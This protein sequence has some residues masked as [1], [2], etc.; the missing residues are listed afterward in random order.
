MK[1]LLP[2]A[3]VTAL[4]LSH[5]ALGQTATT[6]PVGAMTYSL[7]ATSSL[8]NT[9]ISVPLTDSPIF[10]GAVASFGSTTVT[11]SGTPFVAGALSQSGSPYFLRFQSGAQAGRTMLITA[12][13][14]DTVTVDVTN[15]SAQ[16]TNLD[17][18]GFS[19]AANDTV[20]IF[21][22]DTLAS[23]FGSA[24]DTNGYLTG[25]ALKGAASVL[26]ADTVSI[27]NRIMARQDAYFFSTTLGYWRSSASTTNQNNLILYPDTSFAITRRSGRPAL[28]F[29]VLGDVPVVPPKIKT[30]GGNLPVYGSNPF[31]VDMTLGTLNLANW[32]K[33]NSVLSAD[34]IAVYNS[35]LAKMDAYYQKLDGTW[36]K[37]GDT[38]TDQSSF[39]LPAGSFVGFV[40]RGSVSGSS[41]FLSATLPYSF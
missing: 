27:Y 19:V 35:T 33:S 40:K 29:T 37:S 26:S 9:Y 21:L 8:T 30:A 38:S 12:N 11:F 5:P 4:T 22:G 31:P 39:V 23:F 13:T 17:A 28:S 18:S 32:T 1:K 36:R 3:F 6:N 15:N 2:F 25:V 14:A 16:T 7:A 34:T 24:T 20:Q 41:S 10:S